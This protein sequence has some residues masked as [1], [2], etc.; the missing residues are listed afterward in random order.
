MP[1]VPKTHPVARGLKLSQSSG[2]YC[3]TAWICQPHNRICETLCPWG[4][5]PSEWPHP[6]LGGS[7]SLTGKLPLQTFRSGLR[8]AVCSVCHFWTVCAQMPAECPPRVRAGGQ[9]SVEHCHLARL[10]FCFCTENSPLLSVCRQRPS[11]AQLPG[12]FLPELLPARALLQGVP[13]ESLLE[14]AL[15]PLRHEGPLR[16]CEYGARPGSCLPKTGSTVAAISSY[17]CDF[18]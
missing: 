10:C 12:T 13:G 1:N 11:A 2:S 7:A 5:Y 3:M 15:Q 14:Q 18:T 17:F 4:C 16:W 8:T 9:G 6:T